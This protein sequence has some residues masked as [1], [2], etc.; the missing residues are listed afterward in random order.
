MSGVVVTSAA[1][2]GAIAAAAALAAKMRKEEEQMTNYNGD[3]LKGWEFKIVRANTEYF[4]KSE[5][6]QKVCEEEAKSGWEM[7]EKFDNHRVRFK[8]KTD[9]RGSD[10]FSTDLDPYRTNVGIAGGSLVGMILG[11]VF[12]FIGGLIMFILMMKGEVSMHPIILPLIIVIGIV[13][14]I[15]AVKKSRG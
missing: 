1:T 5:N 13:L 8:R 6:L 15:F 12:L 7:V 14:T 3:D 4:R 9:R 2:A 11:I 10:Q